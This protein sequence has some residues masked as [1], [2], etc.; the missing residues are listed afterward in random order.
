MGCLSFNIERRGGVDAV[1][2]RDGGI[3][4]ALTRIGGGISVGAR[5]FGGASVSTVRHGGASVRMAIICKPSIGGDYEMLWTADNLP[6]L[7]VIGEF[8]YVNRK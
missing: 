5:R 6:L 7:T 4:A 3:T 8:L 2:S 1:F